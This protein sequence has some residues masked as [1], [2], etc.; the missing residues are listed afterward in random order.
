MSDVKYWLWLTQTGGLS[1]AAAHKYL[2]HF[3]SVKKLYFAA[4][5]DY[6]LVPEAREPEVRKLM[7]KKLDAAEKIEAE[8]R[9]L[10]I[11]IMSLYD[12]DYPDRLRNIYDAPL[13]LYVKGELPIIDDTPCIA[14][15]GTRKAHQYGQRC[16]QRFGYDITRCGGVVVSG[17]A[18]GIDSAAIRAAL[19][20]GGPV[21]G[22]L[23]TGLDVVFPAWNTQLQNAVAKNGALISEYPPGTKGSK[24][25]FPQRNRII[26]GISVG[27]VVIEAPEK[28]GSLITAARA[29]EQ[30]R[31]VYAVPG[32]IDDPG[33][34]G[35]NMLIR[36]GAALA[37]SGWDVISCYRWQFPERIQRRDSK[38]LAVL[39][40]VKRIAEPRNDKNIAV[41]TKK[42]VDKQNN[43]EYIDLKESAQLSDGELALVRALSE[44]AKLTDE[45]IELTGRE[46]SDVLADLTMLE[47][48]GYVRQNEEN[49]FELCP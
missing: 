42:S 37:I 48:E 2:R 33:F 22:V 26:S 20:A 24:S 8:C 18:E 4:A 1:T 23:G 39:D 21:V 47:L 17:L 45:L 49:R 10:G 46:A 9:K 25:T 3:G 31:D 28:S 7:N 12:A 30:G 11:R 32:N 27:V 19:D 29:S 14:I 6:R 40:A 13:V 36:D 41:E 35:S 44:G 38:K 15:V 16:A 5:E 43:K 34:V